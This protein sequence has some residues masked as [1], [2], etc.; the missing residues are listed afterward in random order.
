M[1]QAHSKFLRL[2]EKNLNGGIAST[3]NLLPLQNHTPR[4]PPIILQHHRSTQPHMAQVFRLFHRRQGPDQIP[5]EKIAR[6]LF[7]GDVVNPPAG[8]FLEKMG[9]L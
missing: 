6:A 8:D 5:I 4:S 9:P 3:P 1:S 7:Q 2:V